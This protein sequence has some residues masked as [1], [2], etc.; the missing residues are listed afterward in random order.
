MN[1]TVNIPDDILT[2]MDH[3]ANYL[4]MRRSEYIR[5]AIENMNSQILKNERYSRLQ[6]LSNLV[7]NE[8]M[9]VNAQF[10]EIEHDPEA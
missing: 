3:N 5:K 4:H 6:Y 2:K 10:E 9:K 8:S 1:V 7:R